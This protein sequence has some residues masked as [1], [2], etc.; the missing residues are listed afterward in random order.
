M[1]GVRGRREGHIV[2]ISSVAGRVANPNSAAYAATKFGVV[3]FSEALRREV[4][5]DRIRVS[6]IE[7]GLVATELRDHIGDAQVKETLDAWADSIRQLQPDDIAEAILFCVTR[8]PHV[9]INEVLIRP[10]DQER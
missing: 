6:V 3:G 8:P 10:T 4:Y 9:N 5:Q 2:N 7:P 1:G